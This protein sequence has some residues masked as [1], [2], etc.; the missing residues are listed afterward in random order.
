[1]I[2]KIRDQCFVIDM[3]NKDEES[4]TTALNRLS[5]PWKAFVHDVCAPEH[6]PIFEKLWD[7]FVQEEIRREIVATKVDEVQNLARI[8]TTR[9]GGK[10]RELNKG[11]RE[12]LSFSS[13]VK[14][15]LCHQTCFECCKK[16]PFINQCLEKKKGNDKQ[17][18]T[19]CMVCCHQNHF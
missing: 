19:L 17:Q 13:Q 8:K 15:D 1:M 2:N 12:D 4:V 7:D 10:K 3:K 11:K 14:K 16:R 5:T 6:M 18:K 9:E